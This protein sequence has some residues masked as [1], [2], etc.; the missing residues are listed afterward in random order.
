MT[1]DPGSQQLTFR[2]SGI[3]LCPGLCN[4]PLRMLVGAVLKYSL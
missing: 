1:L 3:H 2:W 4:T